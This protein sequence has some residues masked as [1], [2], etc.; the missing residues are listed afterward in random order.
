[1]EKY[2][3]GGLRKILVASSH[4]SD[5]ADYF[6]SLTETNSE[7]IDGKLGENIIIK[8]IIT[9]TLTEICKRQDLTENNSK[10]RLVGLQMIEV[11]QANF[12][13]GV[14][15]VNGKY[16]FTFFYFSDLD[17]GLVS[18]AGTGNNIFYA[19]ISAKHIPNNKNP[20][21]DFSPN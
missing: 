3:S 20:L 19:R 7:A 18:L 12:W 8:D 5:I 13:H 11:R 2:S 14:G 17:K 16:I 4:F 10:I 15:F 21:K 6:L 1:M 9:S